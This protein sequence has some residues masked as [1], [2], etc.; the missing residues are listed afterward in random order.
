M[1]INIYSSV[2]TLMYITYL[3]F[4]VHMRPV[5]YTPTSGYLE[6]WLEVYATLSLTFRGTQKVIKI[7]I[8]K[9]LSYV[10]YI[11][12]FWC[13]SQASVMYIQVES[14]VQYLTSVI[15]LDW[16]QLWLRS[17]E[18]KKLDLTSFQTG[19]WFALVLTY[20]IPVFQLIFYNYQLVTLLLFFLASK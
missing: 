16:L 6:Q 14:P 9:F 13:T 17:W 3:N 10:H 4:G 12:K 11:F 2:S 5:S 1:K 18:I 8:P 19:F 20:F 7:N 15:K